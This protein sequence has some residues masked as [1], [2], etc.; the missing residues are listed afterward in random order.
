MKILK[1]N[2]KNLTAGDSKRGASQKM[3]E[4]RQERLNLYEVGRVIIIL[5]TVII[6]IL[7]LV[8]NSTITFAYDFT[9]EKTKIIQKGVDLYNETIVVRNKIL[10]NLDEERILSIEK[11]YDKLQLKIFS[12]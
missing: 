11:E 1:N 5:L 2:K 9:E 4:F 3:D 7:Y 6:P 10:P 12:V 8:F